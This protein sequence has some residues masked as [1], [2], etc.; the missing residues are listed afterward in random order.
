M[1][2]RQ[3]VSLVRRPRSRDAR[4]FLIATED[5]YAGKQ[6]FSALEV[7]GVLDQERVYVVVLETRDG[8]S[9]PQH[10]LARLTPGATVAHGSL[11]AD[12]EV[13]SVDQ[14]WVSIDRDRWP[15]KRLAEVC[16]E[17]R[18]MKVG[19][20]VSVP[21][22]EAW[23]VLHLQP[24]PPPAR[25]RDCK[26][27]L[28]TL[29][30]GYNSANVPTTPWTPTAVASARARARTFDTRPADPWPADPGSRL[31]RLLDALEDA[32][33]LIRTPTP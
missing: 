32:G 21:C 15:D 9:A 11:P 23:L 17:A 7:N 3:S 10:V 24:E 8:Q 16:E 19:V 22:F 31:Y 29:L 14:R 4:I 30:D 1:T 5:T 20:A 2:P 27:H 18:A 25:T 28:R 33:A 12:L 13:S 6:Y 26:Q